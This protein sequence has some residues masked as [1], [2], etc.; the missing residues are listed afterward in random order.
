M[1]RLTVLATILTGIVSWFVAAPPALA[2]GTVTLSGTVRDG[3][4]HGW[5]LWSTVT[6]GDQ[7]IHSSPFNGRYSLQVAANATYTI[8]VQTGAAGYR[9]VTKEV[10]VGNRATVADIAV[11]VDDDS[12]IAAG[13]KHTTDGVLGPFDTGAGDWTVQDLLG[14]GQVWRFDDP[15]RRGNQ[16]GGR[17]GFAILD[18][19]YYGFDQRQD[20]VLVSPVADL[21]GVAAPTIGF[22]SDL[23]LFDYPEPS[24][25]ADVELSLNGGTTWENVWHAELSRRG[26]EQITVPIPQAAGKSSVRMRF[27]WHDA[28]YSAAEWWQVDSAWLGNRSCSPIPGSLVTG[29]VKDRNTS[30]G[31]AGATVRGPSGVPV[32][33]VADGLYSLFSPAAGATEFTGSGPEYQSQVKRVNVANSNVPVRLDFSVAAGRLTTST[34]SVESSQRLGEVVTATVNLRNKGTASATVKLAERP[35]AFDLLEPAKLAAAPVR[36]VDGTFTPFAAGRTRDQVAAASSEADGG[37]AGTWSGVADYPIAISDN[38]AAD[39]QG[40]VY[41]VGGQEDFNYGVKDAF[42]FDPVAGSW[43]RL[44]DL[45]RGRQAPSAAFLGGKLYV[46]DGWS[47]SD[48]GYDAVAVPETDIY[49]PATGQ[50]SS[51]P[52]IPSAAGAA[53]SAVLDDRL[54]VVGGCPGPDQC[55]SNKVFRFDPAANEWTRMADYPES[56]AWTSCGAIEELV[57]C[58]GGTLEG[59]PPR[60]TRSAYVYNPRVDTWTRI[61]DLPIDLWASLGTVAQG[62]FILGGGVTNGT[63]TVTNQTFGYDPLTN[64]WSALANSTYTVYR[65]AG[66]CGFYKIGGGLPTGISSPFV[67]LL[68]GYGDC[69]SYR[70]AAWLSAT[71]SGDIVLR[72]GQSVTVKLRFDASVVSQPGDYAAKL[73]LREDTPYAAPAVDLTMTADPPNR[74]ALLRGTVTGLRCDGTAEA[75][76]GASVWLDGRLDDFTLSTGTD[77]TYAR[78]LDSRNAPATLVVGQ[79]GWVP[80]VRQV[81]L[82]SGGT[83]TV[84]VQLFQDGC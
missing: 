16:T 50:W 11:P 83:T 75:L 37:P 84:D 24:G 27:H 48:F 80:E 78:W 63:Q 54:Y 30:A 41:S 77:G 34:T 52:K 19:E 23:Y 31:L 21:T 66:A 3:S 62:K 82:R 68:P 55:G 45:P 7:T 36:R 59:W 43:S 74:W 72:P 69:T 15:G 1:K 58:A 42:V 64:A 29:F 18:A 13:Y 61:A 10:P 70:D 2:A 73:L 22:R 60:S 20:T 67:E 56:V 12:C 57:Y 14:N 47:E 35:G 81:S 53:G 79:D 38:A 71:P 65:G 5:P 76:P 4:G 25:L 44:P 17:D 26:P 8:T 28:V 6:V 46:V 40:K 51:G 33:S 9:T 32:K 49:D 39:Y